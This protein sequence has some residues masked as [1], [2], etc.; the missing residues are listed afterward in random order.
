M[1]Y[2]KHLDIAHM[3]TIIAVVGAQVLDVLVRGVD[4]RDTFPTVRRLV[5]TDDHAVSIQ[6]GLMHMKRKAVDAVATMRTGEGIRVAFRLT[7][8]QVQ[9]ITCNDN[10]VLYMLPYIRGVGYRDMLRML[11]EVL[12]K[13]IEA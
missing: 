8:T 3:N 13:Y 6:I 12:V 9:R 2:R 11:V 5:G 1:Q 4:I 7:A 10:A